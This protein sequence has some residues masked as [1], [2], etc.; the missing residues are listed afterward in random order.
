MAPGPMARAQAGD[1]LRREHS[2][3]PCNTSAHRYP[4][5]LPADRASNV[6][7]PVYFDRD[8]GERR[9]L[10]VQLGTGRKVATKYKKR[11]P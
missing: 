3:N 7:R 10:Q 4:R 1:L 9:R 2:E 8:F 6:T 5:A 11:I